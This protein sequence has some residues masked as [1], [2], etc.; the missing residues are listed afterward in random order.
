MVCA[1]L[2]TS[3]A[4]QNFCKRYPQIYED[5]VYEKGL[6]PIAESIQPK[7]MQF[8]TNYRDIGLARKKAKALRNTIDFFNTTEELPNV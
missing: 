7:I 4:E 3:D 1:L 8:K 5:V 6:C 2:G